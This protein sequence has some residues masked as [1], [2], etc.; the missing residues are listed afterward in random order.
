MEDNKT[1]KKQISIKLYVP[2][3][4]PRKTVYSKL[5]PKKKS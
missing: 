5:Y 1:D 2:I 3:V 4:Q